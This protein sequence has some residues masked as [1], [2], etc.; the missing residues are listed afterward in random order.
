MPV[1]ALT[2]PF[3]FF[4]HGYNELKGPPPPPSMTGRKFPSAPS[5]PFSSPTSNRH[6]GCGKK[7]LSTQTEFSPAVFFV[8]LPRSCLL[9]PLPCLRAAVYYFD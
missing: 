8:F 5:P 1:C 4:P 7:I 9:A 3:S 2:R 6:R